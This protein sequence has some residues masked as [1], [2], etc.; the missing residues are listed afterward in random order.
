LASWQER[1][2][3]TQQTQNRNQTRTFD[4]QHPLESE[5]LVLNGHCEFGG[6]GRTQGE[7]MAGVVDSSIAQYAVIEARRTEGPSECFVIAY[8]D[9]ESLRDL[10]AAPSIIA[11]GFAS[12]EQ[13]QANIDADF[14]TAVAWMQTSTGLT[15]DAAAKYPSGVLSIKRCLGAGFDL[16]QT[17][18]VV[19]A[20]LQTTVATA[21]LIFYSRNVVSTVIRS[22]VGG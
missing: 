6:K 4:R 17:G 9:E 8:S 11:C 20:F 14:W 19:R 7:V 22:F 1:N 21:I 15:V 16:R 13:A 12:R 18:R 10:I 5:L 2:A 3:D